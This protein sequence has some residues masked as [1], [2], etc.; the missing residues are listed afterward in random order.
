MQQFDFLLVLDLESTCD[1]DK[2]AQA[3]PQVLAWRRC[4]GRFD[5]VCW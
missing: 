5:C 4:W 2:E 3:M 1:R